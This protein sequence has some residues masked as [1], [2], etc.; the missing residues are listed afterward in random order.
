MFAAYVV[1][2]RG[3]TSIVALSPSRVAEAESSGSPLR[4]PGS[5]AVAT[6]LVN[7]HGIVAPHTHWIPLAII[8]LVTGLHDCLECSLLLPTHLFSVQRLLL[9]LGNLCLQIC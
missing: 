8:L 1:V 6:V 3:T 5:S 2:A 9:Y 7:L 4:A